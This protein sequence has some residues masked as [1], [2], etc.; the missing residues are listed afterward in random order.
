MALPAGHEHLRP[1]GGELH[2]EQVALAALA[3]QHGTP[4]YVYSTAAI[5]ARAAR[6]RAAFGPQA[7]IC[8]AVKSNP[9]LHLL[10]LIARLGL[11]FDL[12]SGGELARL[13]AA[14]VDA[15]SAVMAGVAKEDWEIAAALRA[16]ILFVNVESPHE[17]DLLAAAARGAGG[18][19]RV[20][21][22]LNPDVDAGTHAYISTGRSE[23]KFGID[24]R[25]AGQIVRAIG[26]REELE[27]VGYHVH[28]GS[29]IARPQP[30]VDAFE[31]VA[32]WMDEAPERSE[33]VRYYDLGG[34]FGVGDSA[35]DVEALARAL[36]PA[37]E[38]RKLEPVLEPGRYLIAEAGL[39]LTR[40]GGLKEGSARRFVLVDAAMN[41]LL[42][43]ALYG[44]KHTIVPV[45][46]TRGAPVE[47]DV[48]GPVCE[49]ADFLGRGVAL[50]PLARGDL[51]A[52][53][54][55]GAYGAAM[56]SN[57][58]SRRRPAEVLVDGTQ[59][60][61]IRRRERLDELWDAE[62]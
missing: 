32:E 14:G 15:R 19:A 24:L 8:Y 11:G 38:A 30:F 51:L 54:A 57:Y 9:N 39:L 12:V 56:A 58:N 48:V 52:V 41:D 1:R 4:L 33:G 49:S 43:P 50:P 60:R 23:N 26:A 10:R 18:R 13:A 62:A 20:A 35:L 47:V 27:L 3:D 6:L 25:A 7:R 40:V 31:R 44:A 22:R 36:L 37:L 28:L 55:A 59:V 42:R 5:A 61:V 45:R 16:G 2:C 17:L 29:Q 53:L 46:E 34:G 21:V